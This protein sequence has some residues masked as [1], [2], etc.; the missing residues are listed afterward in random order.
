MSTEFMING[1]SMARY[2]SLAAMLIP[3]NDAAETQQSWPYNRCN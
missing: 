3:T 1:G 2:L